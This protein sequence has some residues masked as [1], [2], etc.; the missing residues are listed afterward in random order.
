M[1]IDVWGQH[2]TLKHMQDPMFASLR[3]WNRQEGELP[4]QEL[5]VSVTLAAME[6][7]NID[8]M[9]ISAWYGPDKVL[10]SNDEVADFTA[11]AQGRF[12]GVGSA[13]ITK[14][15]EAVREVYRCIN[16]LGF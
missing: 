1:I 11:Q 16:E 5:P 15:M 6:S 10:I 2:P 13:D 7:A 4:T 3:R 12:I 14:P 8:K 9:L